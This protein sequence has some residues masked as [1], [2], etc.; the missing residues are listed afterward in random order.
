MKNVNVDGTRPYGKDYCDTGG[1]LISVYPSSAT[2]GPSVWVAV[3]SALR[4]GGSHHIALHLKRKGARKLMLRL[5]RF[6]KATR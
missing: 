5:K 6:L 3:N 1:D 2:G 4:D